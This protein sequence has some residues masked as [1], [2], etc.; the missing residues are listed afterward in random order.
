MPLN[1]PLTLSI[2]EANTPLT[3]MTT[4]PEEFIFPTRKPDRGPT[5]YP[6][7]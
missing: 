3:S 7:A 5:S 4:A 2:F 6:L 1:D